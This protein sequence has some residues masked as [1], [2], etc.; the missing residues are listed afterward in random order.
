[1]TLPVS[2]HF[3]TY[4]SNTSYCPFEYSVITNITVTGEGDIA[5]YAFYN[6]TAL[7][8]ISISDKVTSIGKYVFYRCSSLTNIVIPESVD[9]IGDYAFY[10]TSL[11]DITSNNTLPPTCAS[12]KC[13][14][15]STY[16]DAT[17]LVP[18]GCA[19]D[20]A[21][22]SVWERFSNIVVDSS[23]EDSS[24]TVYDFE[25]D[26][27]YYN[28][29]ADDEVEVTYGSYDYNSY[30][31][32]VEIPSSVSY[33]GKSY[34]VTSIGYNAFY[35]SSDLSGVTLPETIKSIGPKAFRNCGSLAAIVLPD[36]VGSVGT[37]AF[38][39]CDSLKSLTLPASA[40]FIDYYTDSS[41][42]PFDYDVISDLTIT[43][44]GDIADYAFYKFTAL[45]NVSIGDEVTG[46]GNY[47]FYNSTSLANVNIPDAVKIIGSYAFYGCTGLTSATIGNGVDS[48]GGYAFRSC[49]SL[50]TV[51]LGTSVRSIGT[52]AFS[53]CTSLTGITI[54]DALEDLGVEAFYCCTSLT[55]ISIPNAKNIGG[56]SFYSC[57][58]LI[59]ASV[60]DGV[61]SIGSKAFYGCSSLVRVSIGDGVEIVGDQAFYNCS[62]LTSIILPESTTSIGVYAFRG[63]SNL[64]SLTLPASASF[65]N[66]KTSSSY[67]PFEYDVITDLTITG[68]GDIADYAFYNFTAL[69]NISI[70]EGIVSIGSYSFST[71]PSLESVSIGE[72]IT[73]IGSS[74]FFGCTSL[75]NVTIPDGIESI[76]TSAFCGC[77]GLTDLTIGASVESLGD[78][79]FYGCSG[80]AD[81]YS[82]NPEPPACAS[83]DCFDEDV[84][85][86]ATL[87]VTSGA[88]SDYSSA[89]V[90]KLFASI[91]DDASTAGIEKIEVGGMSVRSESGKLS[92]SGLKDGTSVSVYSLDG[93]VLT[94]EIAVDGAVQI[95]V[96]SGVVIVKAG[97]WSGKV[98]VM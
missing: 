97:N 87:H 88:A 29:T 51:T 32:D 48:I 38:R 19:S 18:S 10:N 39:G 7:Q 84:Y 37:Y 43:G 47:A 27:I 28:I 36:S 91:A 54:P 81:I 76:G 13:F 33:E 85:E 21:S 26:G 40:S 31:G 45:Q 30:E 57:T 2:T 96:P 55:S 78:F 60:G 42:C 79:V 25:V 59:K 23:S 69:K 49:S 89:D 73:S 17:L 14:T 50:T 74:A 8:N 11:V 62:S 72:G 22:A 90:W 15:S 80:L 83:T 94:K 4:K 5:D 46:I 92:V 1:M 3:T 82:L 35:D 66:Y 64:T 24:A 9:S 41:V 16:S 70:G 67:C 44:D 34:K 56:S 6:F 65:T 77:S 20:Y 75:A 58:G 71:C 12:A 86:S 61:E 95:R 53:Y 63:C 52:N 93:K 68:E 98:A